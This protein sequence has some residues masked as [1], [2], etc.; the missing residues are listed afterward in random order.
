MFAPALAVRP[1]TAPMSQIISSAAAQQ[2]ASAPDTKVQIKKEP[3]AGQLA[4]RERQKTC[5]A[6]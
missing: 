4:P 1:I 2:Q 3:S 6:E 5:A